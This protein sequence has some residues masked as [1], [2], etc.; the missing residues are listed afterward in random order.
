MGGT[1]HPREVVRH[2]NAYFGEMEA[3]I[4][5]HSGLVVQYIGDEIEAV[6]GAPVARPAHAERRCARRSRCAPPGGLERARRARAGAPL[7]NGIGIHTGTVLAGNIGSSDRLSYALV[8]DSVN[9]TSRMQALTKELHQT[10]WSAA[11]P[12]ARLDQDM[13]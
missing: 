9:L 7:R 3:A 2:L 11:P 8:G 5:A 1:T 10:S 12:A 4:R 6:F 13:R